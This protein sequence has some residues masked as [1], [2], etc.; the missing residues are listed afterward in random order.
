MVILRSEE[1][2]SDTKCGGGDHIQQTSYP[3]LQRGTTFPSVLTGLIETSP[4]SSLQ[5]S[6]VTAGAALAW[7]RAPC[8]RYQGAGTASARVSLRPVP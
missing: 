4:F 6:A 2:I 7:Q 1:S 3:A 8:E 5:G